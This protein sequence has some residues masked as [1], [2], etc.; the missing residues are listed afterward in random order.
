MLAK[1]GD[2][3][4][5]AGELIRLIETPALAE[6]WAEKGKNVVSRYSWDTIA[7]KEFELLQ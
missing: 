4:G 7:E 5:F 6:Q 2:I 1:P 3:K